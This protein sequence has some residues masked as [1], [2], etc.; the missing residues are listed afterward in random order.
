MTQEKSM[1][2]KNKSSIIDL[3]VTDE[4]ELDLNVVAN[5]LE[6]SKSVFNSIEAKIVADN[7]LKVNV[8]YKEENFLVYFKLVQNTDII[9]GITEVLVDHD[10]I[11]KAKKANV[12]LKCLVDE[13]YNFIA[14]YYAQIRL[15]ALISDNPLIIVDCTQWC[16]MDG[17]YLKG[18]SRTSVDIIDSNLFKVKLRGGDWLYTEGLERFGIKEFDMINV[19]SRYIRACAGFMSRIAKYFIEFGQQSNTLQK[20]TDLLNDRIYTCLIDIESAI[21]MDSDISNYF[22]DEHFKKY[23]TNRILIT[24]QSSEITLDYTRNSID[25]LEHLLSVKKYYS[26][27]KYLRDKKVMAEETIKDI[28][29]HVIKFE[30]CHNLMVL[31]RDDYFNTKWYYFVKYLDDKFYFKDE[32]VEL[33]ATI[34]QVLDW[35]YQGINPLYYYTIL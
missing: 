3:Y 30:D 20:Y 8:T 7:I 14:A 13:E 2:K 4:S 16:I 34:D 35:N 11:E 29:E 12:Y 19:D 22:I 25:S 1:F 27:D 33:I 24:L 31:A 10:K 18:I 9:D 32:S 15:L 26:S 5:K 28:A 21:K 23:T 17:N 6:G